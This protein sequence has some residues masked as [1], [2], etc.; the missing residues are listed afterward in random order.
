MLPNNAAGTQ[1]HASSRKLTHAL[2]LSY[3]VSALQIDKILCKG[4]PEHFVAEIRE[5]ASKHHDDL[6][7]DVI[8]AY[9]FGQRSGL[10]TVCL[11]YM[12]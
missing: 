5:L 8:R 2:L 10:V 7:V 6:D 4:A 12:Q 11:L 9:H 1:Y 3:L